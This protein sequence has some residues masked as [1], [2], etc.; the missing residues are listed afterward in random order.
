MMNTRAPDGANKIFRIMQT[1]QNLEIG[2]RSM[3][4]YSSDVKELP[5]DCIDGTD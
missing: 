4:D 3:F 2:Y 1:E 5:T